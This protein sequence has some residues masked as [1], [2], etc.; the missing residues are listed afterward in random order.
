MY[1]AQ[2]QING[3]IFFTIL[4]GSMMIYSEYKRRNPSV[5]PTR[6]QILLGGKRNTIKNKIKE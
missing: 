1:I 6:R 5:R 4:G 3:L 2:N